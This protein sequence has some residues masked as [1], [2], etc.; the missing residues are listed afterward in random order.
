MTFDLP[1]L[2][3]VKSTGSLCPFLLLS[4]VK[5]HIAAEN[6]LLAQLLLLLLVVFNGGLADQHKWCIP[7]TY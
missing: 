1:A 5:T 6:G 7:A 3:E 2:V 4:M